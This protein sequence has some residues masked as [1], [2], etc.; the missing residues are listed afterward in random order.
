MPTVIFPA[1]VTRQG[2]TKTNAA[3]CVLFLCMFHFLLLYFSVVMGAI[4]TL[5]YTPYKT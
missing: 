5:V 2:F 1:L 4:S 3:V